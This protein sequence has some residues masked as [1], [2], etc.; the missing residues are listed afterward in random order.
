MQLAVRKLGE[1][2]SLIQAYSSE[3]RQAVSTPDSTAAWSF[4]PTLWKSAPLFMQ[5]HQTCS[6]SSV[7]GSQGTVAG[8]CICGLRLNFV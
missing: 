4:L 6:C 7:I 8:G 2:N 3:V 1:S 5:F